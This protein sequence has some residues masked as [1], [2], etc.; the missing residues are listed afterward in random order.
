[1]SCLNA[2][3]ECELPDHT[4]LHVVLVDDGSTDGTSEAIASLYPL[5]TILE[6]PG[7]LYW[8]RGMY[9]AF[10]YAKSKG[11]DAYLWLNDD[12]QLFAETITTL[13]STYQKQS[14]Q[15]GHDVIVVGSTISDITGKRTYGGRMRS[16]KFFRVTSQIVQPKSYAVECTSM[17]GNI[18]LIPNEV[19]DIVGNVDIRFRHAMGDIDYALRA[20]S[21]GIKLFLAPG[22]LGYCDN[23]S[24]MNTHYDRNLSRRQRWGKIL[25]PKGLPPASWFTFTRKHC[26]IFWPLYFVKPYLMVWLAK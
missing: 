23:N 13:I 1:M 16:H 26:G 20:V 10:E 4:S 8:N 22:F 21:K 17:N 6:G 5:T 12:T 11:Y 9:L 15:C 2:L 19:A 24:I 3:F 14:L 25:G 7:D 18:V